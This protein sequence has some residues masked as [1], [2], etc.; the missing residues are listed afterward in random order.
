MIKVRILALIS[1]RSPTDH[2]LAIVFEVSNL[3]LGENIL[4]LEPLKMRECSQAT[5]LICSFKILYLKELFLLVK[6]PSS[7]LILLHTKK[8]EP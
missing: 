8:L 3:F 4:V 5:C 1:A 7:D 6:F 2:L